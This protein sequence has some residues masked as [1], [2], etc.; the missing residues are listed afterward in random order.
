MKSFAIVLALMVVTFAIAGCGG[1]KSDKSTSTASPTGGNNTTKPANTTPPRTTP[2]PTTPAN[3]TTAPPPKNVTTEAIAFKAPQ[4]LE[5][6]TA[7]IDASVKSL[8]ITV[9]L[10][11]SAANACSLLDDA[12][13]N[14]PP[15]DF[16]YIK[17]LPSNNTSKPD[18]PI[19]LPKLDPT[20]N[21]SLATCAQG[22]VLG[23]V[24]V[25]AVTPAPAG[26]WRFEAHGI[27]VNV[28][29]VVTV[30]MKFV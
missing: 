6:K 26:S 18:F 11:A 15:A 25:T 27:G 28:Q 8:D 13:D 9:V 2:P 21:N 14:G 5:N 20:A 22:A 19:Q 10:K 30:T 7:A 23:N 4:A 16:P 1:K 3:N 17:V 24:T 29:V 12:T